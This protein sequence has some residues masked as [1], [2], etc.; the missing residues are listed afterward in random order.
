MRQKLFK[1]QIG[2]IALIVLLS[3]YLVLVILTFVFNNY[4][5]EEKYTSL[6]KSCET[7]S[8]FV[9]DIAQND[10]QSYTKFSLYYIMQNLSN[11]SGFDIFVTDK[12]G[13]ITI[14][15]DDD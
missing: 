8:D 10:E 7:V 12:N 2:T 9:V 15:S 11:V 6:Q 14:C 13:V 5:S 3:L 4:F 1:K